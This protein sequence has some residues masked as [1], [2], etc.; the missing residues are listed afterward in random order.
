MAK[1]LARAAVF[2]TT[3]AVE[4]VTENNVKTEQEQLWYVDE[5]PDDH[6]WNR[7]GKHH[8][9]SVKL[10]Q[11]SIC[12]NNEEG[13]S[14]RREV[15][16]KEHDTDDHDGMNPCGAEIGFTKA[17]N[18]KSLARGGD[19]SRSRTTVAK[20]KEHFI[21][22]SL[23]GPFSIQMHAR[24]ARNGDL[25]GLRGEPE[26]TQECSNHNEIQQMIH[27]ACPESPRSLARPIQQ[28]LHSEQI[29][30]IDTSSHS[31]DAKGGSITENEYYSSQDSE[32]TPQRKFEGSLLP[33]V[34]V[35][36]Q[37]DS[38]PF[39]LRLKD[40]D[41]A[42]LKTGG[43]YSA[44]ESNGDFIP[45]TGKDDDGY[46]PPRSSD[47]EE[48]NAQGKNHPQIRPHIRKSKTSDRWRVNQPNSISPNKRRRTSPS[49]RSIDLAT[50]LPPTHKSPVKSK[51][52][53]LND[54]REDSLP[55]TQDLAGVPAF[56]STQWL[57]TQKMPLARTELNMLSD[58]FGLPVDFSPLPS[59]TKTQK[60]SSDTPTLSP[61]PPWPDP[62][63]LWYMQSATLDSGTCEQHTYDFLQYTSSLD[64]YIE[65]YSPATCPI[66]LV[67][68]IVA[69]AEGVLMSMSTRCN[70][71]ER[72][73]PHAL[74]GLLDVEETH[75]EMVEKLRWSGDMGI[76]KYERE[77]WEEVQDDMRNGDELGV[78]RG[79]EVLE[80]GLAQM[81]RLDEVGTRV[82]FLKGLSERVSSM[83]RHARET[84]TGTVD[85]AGHRS[86]RTRVGEMLRRAKPCAETVSRNWR[87]ER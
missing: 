48:F 31:K 5:E 86:R 19:G 85:E 82:A 23:K 55:S 7:L 71:I 75:E 14:K 84:D 68:D 62:W 4:P 59:P 52:D 67:K 74:Q 46:S 81:R 8:Q 21:P 58:D 35:K 56:P 32:A 47:L 26:Q 20:R 25:Y 24:Q 18:V 41:D 22:P 60:N 44:F 28:L 63:R 43:P 34:Q 2:R 79:N 53:T 54:I 9:P 33:P 39:T 72:T 37:L 51:P 29:S 30:F 6:A 61:I 65:K 11:D 15:E 80:L 45:F 10:T 83:V 3:S 77:N 78:H 42:V 40:E 36:Q 12:D 66:D 1:I 38:S 76:G 27:G 13:S 50:I 17:L 16:L 69:C 73:A 57:S 87:N 49:A 70:A 64:D